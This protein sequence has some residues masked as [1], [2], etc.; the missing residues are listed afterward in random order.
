MIPAA[1]LTIGPPGCG[2]TTWLV[3]QVRGELRRGTPPGAIAI[4]TFTRSARD[5]LL[6]RLASEF[7]LTADE[8]PWVRTIH[9]TAFRLLELDKAAVLT[10]A[11]WTEFSEK[12]GY[13]LSCTSAFDPEGGGHPD[14]AGRTEDD[15]L[16][17]AREWGANRRLRTEEALSR[18][19]MNVPARRYRTFCERV[20]RFKAEEGLIEFS[21]M[22][23]MA[24]HADSRPPVSVAFIDEGQDLSP[25]QVALV[26]KWF[27]DCERV[28]IAADDDQAI[29]G[30]GGADPAWLLEYAEHGSVHV[31]QQSHR[32]PSEIH[33]CANRIIGR[34]K[35]RAAKEWRPV[36]TG[37][38]VDLA[39]DLTVPSLVADR[40]PT[41]V[42]V[43]NRTSIA[44]LATHLFDA[45]V[46]FVVDGRGGPNPL[47][48]GRLRVAVRAAQALHCGDVV[49][50]AELRVLVEFI[51]TFHGEALLPYGAK[52]RFEDLEGPVPVSVVRSVVGRGRLFEVMRAEGPTGVLLTLPAR[53]RRYVARLLTKYGFLP[54]PHVV[55]TTIHTAKGRE[56]D[57]VIVATDMTRS[58]YAA[59]TNRRTHEAEN[60][61]WYVAA[62]R[63]KDELVWLRPRSRRHFH[64]PVPKDRTS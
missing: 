7:D 2:K 39:D 28:L 16:L 60:R 13:D 54:T 63:A 1:M 46:P 9:S 42:L 55:V 22:L 52:T 17:L 64:L 36:R 34:N 18:C 62:T 61:V 21:E 3:N 23:D 59:Y 29:Y 15:D 5:E 12:Y 41:F 37:G 26:E 33:A 49:D 50:A 30:F 35:T 58:T 11:K 25:A 48:N 57:R 27:A 47:A 10:D 14:L 19:P 43:R 45:D 40:R 8:L 56:A 20:E 31:L 4:V 44:R 38:R 32:V 24:L 51:P 6:E 53:T